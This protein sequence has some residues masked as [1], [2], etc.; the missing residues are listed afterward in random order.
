LKIATRE[1][2]LSKD[3]LIF[4]NKTLCWR[5]SVWCG[6]RRVSFSMSK[7]DPIGDDRWYA[8]QCLARREAY[9]AE[10]LKVQQFKAFNPFF[11]KT[12]RHARQFRTVKQALFPGYLFVALDLKKDRW[13]SVN[14]TMGV[15]RLIMGGEY[16]QPVP[17]GVV[18]EIIAKLDEMDVWRLNPRLQVGSNARVVSGPFT[19]ILG[20]ILTLNETGRAR[21]L[22]E[23]MSGKIVVEIDQ[24]KLQLAG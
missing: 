15:S 22:L 20:Q 13:R 5:Q 1:N 11:L 17:R 3:K 12:V 16:P 8:V 19:D 4:K 9:A 23:I 18:E 7:Q 10:N 2:S 24:S 6:W 14:G 21:V